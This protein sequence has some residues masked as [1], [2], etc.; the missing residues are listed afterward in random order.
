MEAPSVAN[1]ADAADAANKLA[2]EMGHY[3]SAV[4]M[5]ERYPHKCKQ[6]ANT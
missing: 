5:L 6:R 3:V 2:K 4:T 1:A